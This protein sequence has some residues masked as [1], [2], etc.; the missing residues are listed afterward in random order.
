VE[1]CAAA[2]ERMLSRRPEE[3]RALAVGAASR[4]RTLEQHF[5]S[6][7]DTYDELLDEKR[8]L[9]RGSSTR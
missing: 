7:L 9:E 2:I 3:L 5:A 8:A 6:V 1:A 4:V